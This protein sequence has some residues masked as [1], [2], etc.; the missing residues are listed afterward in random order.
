MEGYCS[1]KAALYALCYLSFSESVLGRPF[2]LDVVDR[3]AEGANWIL[4]KPSIPKKFQTLTVKPRFE[5]LVKN[6][7]G[8]AM[9]VLI[10]LLTDPL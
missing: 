7:E 4:G 1:L 6:A 9:A 3:V 10:K 2:I 8:I 5:H